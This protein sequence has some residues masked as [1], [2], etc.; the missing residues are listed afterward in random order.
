MHGKGIEAKVKSNF[1]RKLL[2]LQVF[3]K[4]N[5]ICL[6]KS[7]VF[8]IKSVYNSNPFIVPNGIKFIHDIHRLPRITGKIPNILF[9]SNY[10]QDKGVLILLDA[11]VILKDKGYEFNVRIVG[12]PSNISIEMLEQI[13]VNKNLNEFAKVTGPL[14]GNDKLLEFQN[15]DLFVFPSY[16]DAFPLVIL[17]AMQFSLPVISTFEG[18]IPDIVVDGETGFLVETHNSTLLSDKIAI[19]LN[20]KEL[21]LRMGHNAYKEF[22]NKYTFSHFETN[23][24]KTL[25]SIIDIK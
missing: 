2:Y 22:E 14:Y 18:G 25:Q 17:E 7:L 11:L 12:S 23:M 5:V 8:D 24:Y 1:L 19:L 16:N 13:I 4:V 3:K 10:K 15:A 21:R 9:L 6:S 20:N